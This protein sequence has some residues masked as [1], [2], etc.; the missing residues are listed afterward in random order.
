LSK[1]TKTKDECFNTF[2]EN[3]KFITE[4]NLQ[5]NDYK[6]DHNKFSCHTSEEF[7][8]YMGFDL[9]EYFYQSKTIS[10]KSFYASNDDFPMKFP[11]S[12]DWR[13]KNAVTQVKD[14]GNCGSCWSFSTTGSLEGAYA[15]KY[16]QL[17]SFSEQQLVSCDNFKNKK[18]RG[19]NLGCDGGLMNSAFEW[20][21]NNDGL[22]TEE[23]Y[24]YTSG[25]GSSE[26]CKT[27]NPDPKSDI[28]YYV[29][30]ESKS[31]NNFMAG[32]LTNPISV[33]IEADEKTFQFYKSGVLKATDC[34]IDIDHGVLV[35]GWGHDLETNL[36]YWIVK[37]SWGN[38]WGNNG[39]IWL[40]KGPDLNF[41]F[42]TCGILTIPSYPVL[43]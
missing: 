21:E 25:D 14:Q 34:G 9:D 2:V 33:A 1:L 42:G 18:N 32:L 35:V 23:E 26:N 27:C 15:I 36:D 24:P 41:G 8:K 39:Y 38:E 22:C 13:E 40:E 29:D 30:I 6:L 5:N 19:N 28:D 7:K 12:W 4:H 43:K 16:K 10:K 17:K 37:N 3:D 20:I 11:E 31:E